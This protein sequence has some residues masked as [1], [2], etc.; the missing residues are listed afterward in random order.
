MATKNDI[1]HQCCQ[2]PLVE[3]KLLEGKTVLSG[4]IQNSIKDNKGALN[5][6]KT[7]KSILLNGGLIAI[8]LIGI[9]VIC[10]GL[11][12]F[13][14]IKGSSIIVRHTF[15]YKVP[16]TIVLIFIAAVGVGVVYLMV[17]ALLAMS[18]DFDEFR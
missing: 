18:D 3:I 9:T 15:L 1:S 6:R 2:S 8:C 13:A 14:A 16:F 12:A 4:S 5:N 17:Q 10:I 7:R 11:A